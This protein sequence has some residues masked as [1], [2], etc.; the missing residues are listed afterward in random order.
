MQACS[1]I[2]APCSRHDLA[3]QLPLWP[4]AWR[5][6]QQLS[7]G[8]GVRAGLPIVFTCISRTNSTYWYCC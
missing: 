4:P 3:A 1:T 2:N 6:A 8:E 7:L 5:E